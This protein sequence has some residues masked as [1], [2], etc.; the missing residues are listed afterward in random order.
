MWRTSRPPDPAVRAARAVVV[1]ATVVFALV[2]TRW[3][4][5]D[6]CDRAGFSADFYDEQAR[7]FLRGRLWVRP[8]VAGNEGF[9]VDGR[10]YLYFGPLL[11]LL[12]VPFALFGEVFAGRLTRLSLVAAHVTFLTACV[13]LVSDAA[14]ARLGEVVACWGPPARVSPWRVGA[15]VAAAAASPALY[16]AGWVSVYHETELWAAALAAWAAVGVLRFARA[17]SARTAVL[18]AAAVAACTLTRA[19]IGIGMGF[20]ATAVAASTFWSRKLGRSPRFRDQNAGWRGA[21]VLVAGCAVGILGHAAVNI[22][23]FGT[24]LGLPAERQVLTL[25]NAERA[26]WFAG[27]DGSFFSTRFLPTTLVQYLRPDTLAV[28]R[29]LPFVRF[30]APAVDRGSYP[31]ETITPA[32]SL[33][34]SATLL[35]AA[36]AVGLVLIVRDR[37]WPWLAL[38]A[39]GVIA[40]VPTFT[41]GFIAN[42]YLAD[43]LPALVVPAGYAFAHLPLPRRAPRHLVAVAR[44]AVVA[45]VVWG[46]WVNVALA[47]WTQNLKEPGFTE[48]RYRVDGWIFGD[49]APGLALHEPGLPAGRDGTVA[50]VIDGPDTADPG[51]CQGVYVAEDGR[52]VPLERAD[53]LRQQT[54]TLIVGGASATGTAVVA[55][56]DGW[57]VGAEAARG[58][59]V[60]A[61]HRDAAEATSSRPVELD[62]RSAL[63]VRVVADEINGELSVT[64]D[65]EE[66]LF[67]F[68]VPPGPVVRGADL[69]PA[70]DPPGGRLCRQLAARR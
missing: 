41:I 62:G 9:L 43:M 57:M 51:A 13:H 20:A 67:S 47:T 38:A 14:R 61:L 31:V 68:A 39:G 60:F 66:A 32:S 17:P 35:A 1:A 34:A 29:L 59:V 53:G 54:G 46:L 12:R 26:A 30:G 5:W 33:P 4:P 28:E 18:P 16:L 7:A 70:A 48:L 10:T 22:A 27:N 8:E 49:P 42:R 69:G 64:V 2:V 65:G 45:L 50:L 52:W 15:F 23:R 40:A 11:A 44:A 63:Q 6:L 21:G 37:A 58:S 55:S 36:A 3:R 19:P 24:A 56:G 25:Q